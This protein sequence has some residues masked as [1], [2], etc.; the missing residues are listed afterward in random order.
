MEEAKYAGALCVQTRIWLKS[1][2]DTLEFHGCRLRGKLPSQDDDGFKVCRIEMTDEL[3]YRIINPGYETIQ[4]QSSEL[5]P[6]RFGLRTLPPYVKVKSR[7]SDRTDGRPRT[8]PLS[9]SRNLLKCAAALVQVGFACYTLY[10]TRSDQTR[11]YGYA[12]FG[13]TVIPYAVM[14]VINL[15]AN[16]L[17]PEYPTMFM[18]HSDVLEEG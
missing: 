18:V 17:S 16:L 3:P 7:L 9:C 11:K 14:S 2:F 10:R 1:S 13:L 5:A 4:G 6:Y 8:I 12:A 15:I